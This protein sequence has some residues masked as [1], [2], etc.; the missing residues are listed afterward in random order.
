MANELAS[1]ILGALS[2][3]EHMALAG[4]SPHRCADDEQTALYY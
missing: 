2:G 1:F 4:C 3:L